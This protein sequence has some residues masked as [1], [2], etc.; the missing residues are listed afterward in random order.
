MGV[1]CIRTALERDFI[2]KD[3]YFESLL[4]L[5]GKTEANRR[6]VPEVSGP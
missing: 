5:E 2:E 4:V 3:F 1:A 6:S